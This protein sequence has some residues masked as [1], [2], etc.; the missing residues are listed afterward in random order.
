[1][2][3]FLYSSLSL[4]PEER[5]L[6]GEGKAGVGMDARAG[7]ASPKASWGNRQNWG[8]GSRSSILCLPDTA[9]AIPGQEVEAVSRGPS[10]GGAAAAGRPSAWGR[11][12]PGG[13]RVGC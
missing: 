7:R 9:L 8:P 5:A 4:W 6:G 11:L 13:R 1:M 12:A 3:S 10:E 2:K